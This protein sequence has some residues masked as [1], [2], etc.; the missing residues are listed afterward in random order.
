MVDLIG[1]HLGQYK[2]IELWGRGGMATVYEA[3][4]TNIE[5]D[6]AI[7]VIQADPADTEEFVERFNREAKAVAS[8]SHPHILK[9]FDYGRQDVIV[10]LVM[11][12]HKRGS[13]DKWI[14]TNP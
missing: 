3:R 8:L 6:V 14:R 4:Q 12:L 10:Y 1:H 13:L 9:V 7:K 11:E 5:R 2:V